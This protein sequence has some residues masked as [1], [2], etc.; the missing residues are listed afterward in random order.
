MTPTMLTSDP[1]RL[2]AMLEA[3]SGP[4]ALLDAQLVQW[5]GTI[6]PPAPTTSLDAADAFCQAVAPGVTWTMN[7]GIAESTAT[8]TTPEG[9]PCCHG[10]RGA[11]PA[12][13]LLA[14]LLRAST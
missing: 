7:G 1:A 9:I 6:V 5:A 13:A 12:L 10:A 4:S 2:A 11:T 3:S 14:A 8:I